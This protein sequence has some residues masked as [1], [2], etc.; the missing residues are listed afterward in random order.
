M[1]ILDGTSRDL[2]TSFQLINEVIIPVLKQGNHTDR[3]LVAINQCDVAMKGRYWDKEN[4]CPEPKLVE[5]LNEKVVSTRKR[6]LEATGVDTQP[7]YYSAGYKDGDE[8]Q[9]PYNLMKLLSFMVEATPESKR[10]NLVR[11]VNERKEMWESDEDVV[12]HREKVEQSVWASVASAAKTGGAIGAEIGGLFGSA[13]RVVG[14]VI[15]TV[16]GGAAGI[17]GSLFG[18]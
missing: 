10:V 9:N 15:G 17:V 7:I 5:F 18:W 2:G 12:K 11:N 1:V 4:N 16:I 3:L 8:E 6:I 14:T 13:G